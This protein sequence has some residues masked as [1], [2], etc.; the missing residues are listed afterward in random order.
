MSTVST[1]TFAKGATASADTV[2]QQA[3]LTSDQRKQIDANGDGKFSAGE[4]IQ[5]EEARRDTLDTG[6]MDYVKAARAATT[7]GSVTHNR[8]GSYTIAVDGYKIDVAP[9]KKEV[10]TVTVT[11]KDGR[12]LAYVWGD[13]HL[14]TF[15]NGK[16]NGHLDFTNHLTL[17]I[18]GGPTVNLYT[19]SKDGKSS[20]TYVDSVIVTHGNFAAAVHG[21]VSGNVKGHNMTDS[22]SYMGR[23]GYFGTHMQE[24]SNDL[25]RATLRS[26]ASG[27]HVEAQGRKLD[28]AGMTALDK[29]GSAGGQRSGRSDTF[30]Y[31]YRSNFDMT[32]PR[33]DQA[34]IYSTSSPD[35]ESKANK[36]R[37]PPAAAAAKP[38]SIPAVSKV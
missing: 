6:L 37:T 26:D 14:N 32:A 3:R 34:P 7:E 9:D 21:L 15:T 35:D 5:Y 17:K 23:K 8:D 16:M 33:F 10:S 30:V 27:S 36:K 18:D 24:L 12:K 11:D 2:A 25:N 22:A 28:Q 29:A 38:T 13:P 4:L 1:S 20:A 31:V 19:K